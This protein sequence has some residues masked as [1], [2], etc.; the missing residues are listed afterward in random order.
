[1]RVNKG[2]AAPITAG[3]V[4]GRLAIVPMASAVMLP[5]A[6]PGIGHFDIHA[7]GP[8]TTAPTVPLPAGT[9]TSTNWSGYAA[10]GSAAY[11]S[12]STSWLQPAV[13]CSTTPNSYAAFW[14]GLDGYASS[15]VEQT[16]TLAECVGRSAEHYGWYETYPNPMYSFGGAIATGDLLTATV[17]SISPTQF[18]LTLSDKPASSRTKP[19]SVT[20]SQTLKTA[21]ALSSAEVIAEAPSSNY[22]VL[23]LADFGTASFINP[24]V[25]TTPFSSLT[26]VTPIEM[27]SN[28]GAAE[29]I[30][31]TL[32]SGGF[33]VSWK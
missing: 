2:V 1:M 18:T 13:S 14:D 32:T 28:R 10:I 24:A 21:A 3:A 5:F 22:G 12:V 26:G 31:S 19:W 17:T 23:P 6:E 11:K 4:V 15:T 25:G 20:T 29:A 8:H 9:V 7:A 33:T 16:G 27:V 30:P